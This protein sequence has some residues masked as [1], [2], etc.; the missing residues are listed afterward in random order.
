[1]QNLLSTP[2][3]PLALLLHTLSF[4]IFLS[5]HLCSHCVDST[6]KSLPLC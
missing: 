2:S 6:T 5:A 1:M 3:M 4:D